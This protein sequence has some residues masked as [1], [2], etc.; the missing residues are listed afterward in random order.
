MRGAVILVG[1][2]VAWAATAQD[3]PA[4][5]A[6]AH[7]E[8]QLTRSIELTEL[9]S[10]E[11]D[12]WRAVVDE[13]GGNEPRT[14]QL[15]AEVVRLQ[16]V[17]EFFKKASDE[18]LCVDTVQ[19]KVDSLVR[20]RIKEP[21]QCVVDLDLTGLRAEVVSIGACTLPIEEVKAGIQRVSSADPD[22]NDL[23]NLRLVVEVKP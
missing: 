16:G 18:K 9:A 10:A 6:V 2:S 13:L 11:A 19:R 7:C 22:C 5:A 1:C 12:R 4:A 8:E 20:L 14:A 23:E 3:I 21:G 17:V 15:T